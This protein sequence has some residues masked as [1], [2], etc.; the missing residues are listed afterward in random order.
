M[1]A[2]FL[3]II[4]LFSLSV[5]ATGAETKTPLDPERATALH[6]DFTFETFA[7]LPQASE[8]ISFSQVDYD[9]LAAAVFHETNRRRAGHD[10]PTLGYRQE[11]LKAAAIQAQ[12]MRRSGIISHQHPVQKMKTLADRINQVGLRPS[13]S[14]E[15]VAMTFGIRYEG[16]RPVVPRQKDGA[17]VF[18]YE[19]NG[20]PIAPHTY[21]SFAQT[22]LDQWMD[23]PGHRKN[24]LHQKPEQ[25]GAAHAQGTSAIGMDIFYCAQVFFTELDVPAGAEVIQVPGRIPAF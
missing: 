20:E 5:G 13:F 19:P 14:A 2:N 22:L 9:L 23:S 21:L 12:G 11:L 6:Q 15:N 1:N 25:L 16:G 3:G 7:D 10:L 17:T 18:S 4:A 24:I 8:Q